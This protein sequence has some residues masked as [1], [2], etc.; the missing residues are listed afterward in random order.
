[1]HKNPR[2][3]TKYWERTSFDINI[4]ECKISAKICLLCLLS[5]FERSVDSFILNV[6]KI[7]I[8]YEDAKRS[9]AKYARTVYTIL[10][11]SLLNILNE[12]TCVKTT[13]IFSG[14]LIEF[15]LTKN[16]II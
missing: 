2:I 3:F 5:L 1:M 12:S 4:S 14:T 13:V 9:F 11:I 6:N 7:S 10:H 8:V 16:H 15:N